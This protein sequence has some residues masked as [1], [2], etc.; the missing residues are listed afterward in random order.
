[1]LLSLLDMGICRNGLCRDLCPNIGLN[2]LGRESGIT[3]AS[4]KTIC[5]CATME[6]FQCK[7]RG[8]GIEQGLLQMCKQ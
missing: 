1:M 6:C 3:C 4:D 2:T 5:V 7:L 8:A